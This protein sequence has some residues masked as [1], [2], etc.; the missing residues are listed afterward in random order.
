MI[1]D[2]PGHHW[3]ADR[4]VEHDHHYRHEHGHWD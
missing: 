3:I 1:A 4:W 2:R